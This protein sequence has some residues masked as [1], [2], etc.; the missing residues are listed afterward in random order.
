MQQYSFWGWGHAATPEGLALGCGDQQ[1]CSPA[2]PHLPGLR[3]RQREGGSPAGTRQLH[4]PHWVLSQELQSSGAGCDSGSHSRTLS[5]GKAQAREEQGRKLPEKVSP[6]PRAVLRVLAAVMLCSCSE[7]SVCC[8][9]R[10]ADSS[11]A[12]L[13]GR[14]MHT[15]ARTHSGTEG[16]VHTEVL[17]TAPPHLAGT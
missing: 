15:T 13:H 12:P 14:S 2:G 11:T 10:G 1:L 9:T 3:R 4:D 7:A 5:K 17:V 16:A 6:E 8:R